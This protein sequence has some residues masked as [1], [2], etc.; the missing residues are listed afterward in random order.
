M[1]GLRVFVGGSL[2]S[3]M[4]GVVL[5]IEEHG[6]IRFHIVKAHISREHSSPCQEDQ[7]GNKPGATTHVPIFYIRGS[8]FSKDI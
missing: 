2:V 6:A 1:V 8:E 5:S 7:S 3:R 4:S